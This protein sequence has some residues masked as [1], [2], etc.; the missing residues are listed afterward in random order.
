M[1]LS[2][3][4]DSSVPSTTPPQQLPRSRIFPPHVRAQHR[5]L[6]PSPQ[7]SVPQQ[8]PQYPNKPSTDHIQNMRGEALIASS[9]G[10]YESVFFFFR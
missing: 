7:E 10:D 6:I 4:T 5:H 8:A 1:T 3:S 2:L 9:R